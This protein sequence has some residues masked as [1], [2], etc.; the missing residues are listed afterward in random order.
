MT[1]DGT[2][3][4][5]EELGTTPVINANGHVTVL[6]GSSISPRVR[7]AME[8]AT[9]Y[10][11]DMRDLLLKSG[12]IMAP[13]LGAEAAFVTSGAASALVLG[14]AACLSG[15]DIEKIQRLP[16]TEGMKN[17]VIIFNRMKQMAYRY[18][19]CFETAGAKLVWVGS[20]EEG[21]I[22]DIES[23]IG[24]NTALIQY[25]GRAYAR[26]GVPPA[27][28]LI[29]LGKRHNVPVFVD[30]AGETWPLDGLTKYALEG[31]DLV[32]YAA[33][34]FNAPH[35]TG[36]LCGKQEL[37]DIAFKHNFVAFQYGTMGVGRGYKIERQ[38]IVAAVEALREWLTMDHEE[39]LMSEDAKIRTIAS[40]IEGI[41][42]VR[43]T[44]CA[45]VAV[46]IGNPL[47]EVSGPAGSMAL[48]I[49]PQV[50]GK[51]AT[52]V[53][54]ELRDGDLSIVVNVRRADLAAG[55]ESLGEADLLGLNM[56]CV[57]DGQ[58]QTIA[59]RLRN[60]L[61]G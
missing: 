38:E 57:H 4:V 3:S 20:E 12:E 22:E 53:A 17:E 46:G 31:A 42:G 1:T 10:Y 52:E 61:A 60:A 40:T 34:Y 59:E 6:G 49:D 56:R 47:P 36:V 14:T 24:P 32:A 7:R 28:E 5:W 15:D 29:A 23:A 19:R 21:T 35:S 43:V 25:L 58:E 8:E 39:R 2:R 33:K 51:T 18:W 44:L 55:T 54:E 37:V 11:V 30:A 45:T 26:G 9:H 27:K 48:E 16:N 41:P 13:M 50:V